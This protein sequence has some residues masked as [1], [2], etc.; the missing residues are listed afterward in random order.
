MTGLERTQAPF[1]LAAVI[2][3]AFVTDAPRVVIEI[4][5]L[6]VPRLGGNPPYL[7]LPALVLLVAYLKLDRSGD[8]GRPVDDVDLLLLLAVIFVAASEAFHWAAGKPPDFRLANEGLWWFLAFYVVRHHIAATRDA[9][10]LGHVAL[11]FIVG[12][13]SLHLCLLALAEARGLT[14]PT[15][16]A[17]ISGRNGISLLLAGGVYLYWFVLKV[18][19]PYP[20]W[21]GLIV[22]GLAFAHAIANHARGALIV[23]LLLTLSR[24]ALSLGPWRK[25]ALVGLGAIVVLGA[26]SASYGYG[27]LVRAQWL[28]SA[29][30]VAQD[31]GASDD[32]RSA[33]YRLAA[34]SALVDRVLNSPLV[35]IGAS[36]ALQERAGDYPSHTYYVLLLAAYGAPGIVVCLVAFALTLYKRNLDDGIGAVVLAMFVVSV[37][38]FVND[39]YYWLA[40]LVAMAYAAPKGV[41]A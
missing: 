18:Y 39:L 2:L 8:R 25:A 32:A 31:A 10:T 33:V 29:A 36:D 27:V 12:M 9:R 35:G 3:V 1:I 20:W 15:L 38:T 21:V 13:G 40:M 41:K 6:P 26:L 28:R 22:P 19:G 30:V 7:L 11:A 34:N 17:E 37:L 24:M 14:N 23:L 5:D 4:F 16:L